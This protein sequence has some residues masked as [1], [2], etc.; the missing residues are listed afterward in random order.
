MISI[1]GR[2]TCIALAVALAALHASDAFSATTSKSVATWRSDLTTSKT[3]PAKSSSNVLPLQRN[4][5][6]VALVNTLD[7]H[8]PNAERVLN[9]DLVLWFDGEDWRC[10]DDMCAHRFA[11][12]SEGRVFQNNDDTNSRRCLSCSYHGW[13]FDSQGSCT[14]IPQALDPTKAGKS[15]RV[16]SYP[17]QIGAGIVWVWPDESSSAFAGSVPLPISP[18]LQQ[19]EKEYAQSAFQREMPYGYELLAENVIDMS[20]LPF[21][22]HEVL[23]SRNNGVQLPFKMLSLDEKEKVWEKESSSI[24]S[25]ATE[26]DKVLPT[27]QVEIKQGKAQFSDPIFAYNLMGTNEAD[28]NSTS[29]LGFY[30]PS[31]IRYHRTPKSG[32]SSNTELFVCPQ[33]AGKCR[34]IIFNPFEGGMKKL[35]IDATKSKNR[36]EFLSN[37]GQYLLRKIILKKYMGVENHLF[38]HDVFDGDNI[39]LARQ[40]ERLAKNG[41]DYTDYMVP[42]SADTLS[43]IFRKWLDLAAEATMRTGCKQADNI[44]EAAL[45]VSL[46]G[47]SPYT[48]L[49]QQSKRELLDRYNS[50]TKSCPICSQA[51]SKLEKRKQILNFALP[52]FFGATGASLIASILSV[53]VFGSANL[54]SKLIAK[55]S[56]R[57]FGSC[58]LMSVFSVFF[59]SR[60]EKSIQKFYYVEHSHQ[61]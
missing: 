32:L 27:Y 25:N 51:L 48:A 26:S 34:V 9:K 47:S 55:M 49:P 19:W 11:P 52:T 5:W 21:S 54:P 13:E 15:A 20:H 60:V 24:Y 39:F 18:M 46:D 10:M 22:H 36:F 35:R 23:S 31:H 8:S 37:I 56:T 58:L 6:P 59:K 12:L 40:G 3:A 17:V 44:V 50:H 38:T 33:S 41:L 16:A 30:A 43:K 45:G 57:L 4:W 29:H 42:S 53:S 7:E 61:D 28:E 14:K 1:T 2:S